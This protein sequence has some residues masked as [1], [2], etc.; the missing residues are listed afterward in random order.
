VRQIINV[1]FNIRNHIRIL[2]EIILG[3]SNIMFLL[4]EFVIMQ[5]MY[6]QKTYSLT[7]I[8]NKIGNWYF[9]L[10]VI[11]QVAVL[12]GVGLILREIAPKN[13]YFKPKLIPINYSQLKPLPR[14]D[15]SE[16]TKKSSLAYQ[17]FVCNSCRRSSKFWDFHHR[18]G[19]RSNNSPSNCEALCPAC[20]ADKTRKRRF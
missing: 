8:A 6:P 2:I 19:N 17:G 13:Y 18:D 16:S 15:F 11:Q 5:V 20:H 4:F 12:L 1:K 3:F 9:N 7:D 10:N 14:K